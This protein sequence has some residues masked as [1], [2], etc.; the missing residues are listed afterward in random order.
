MTNDSQTFR[1]AMAQLGSAVCI[2]STDG[3]A[4][5]YGIT[6]SAVTAV[7]DDPASLI[8]CVNRTSG[9][10]A[11]MKTNGRICVNVLS[12]DQERVSAAFSTS[13]I[14]PADR[15]STGEWGKS[16]VGN[17]V[18]KDTA[19]HFD[20]EIDKALEYGTH[21]VFFCRALDISVS[22]ATTCLIYQ[23]R[24]YHKIED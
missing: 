14:A 19:A 23:G 11:V 18:L 20:C 3:P 7:S 16:D 21:T 8:V 6:A 4:G 10:N 24:A 9:A 12:C 1:A 13:S 15:F 22:S 5:R 2:L 17:P